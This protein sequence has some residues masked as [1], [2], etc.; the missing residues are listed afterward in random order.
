MHLK[1]IWWKIKLKIKTFKRRFKKSDEQPQSYIY[2][3]D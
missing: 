3:E 2:E 1:K